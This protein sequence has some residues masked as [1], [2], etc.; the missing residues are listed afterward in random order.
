MC[1][2][3][4][5]ELCICTTTTV[6]LISDFSNLLDFLT[7]KSKIIG[8]V[9]LIPWQDLVWIM[10]IYLKSYL[11]N[12]YTGEGSDKHC[13]WSHG[14]DPWSLKNNSI[15]IRP[16]TI[17]TWQSIKD[18]SGIVSLKHIRIVSSRKMSLLQEK[19]KRIPNIS[20]KGRAKKILDILH[21]LLLKYTSCGILTSLM[22]ND[23]IFFDYSPVLLGNYWHA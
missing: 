11:L 12:R 6:F 13:I 18:Q 1:F 19:F 22:V 21:S 16:M 20:A 2:F 7:L 3:D 10:V 8:R 23:T 4:S 14:I 9:I 5:Y 17:I 15:N